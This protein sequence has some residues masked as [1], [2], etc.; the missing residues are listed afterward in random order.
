MISTQNFRTAMVLAVQGV[1]MFLVRVVRFSDLSQSA[2]QRYIGVVLLML[3]ILQLV[4][5]WMV[6]TQWPAEEGAAW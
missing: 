5:V 1:V 2:V 4:G 6:L 3:A